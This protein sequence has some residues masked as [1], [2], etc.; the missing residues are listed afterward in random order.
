MRVAAGHGD[1]QC[2]ALCRDD[3]AGDPRLGRLVSLAGAH[4]LVEQ[5]G[6]GRAGDAGCGAGLLQARG[7][8]EGFWR[9]SWAA[10]QTAGALVGRD[11]RGGSAMRFVRAIASRAERVLVFQRT[12]QW[13][14]PHP[15]CHRPVPEDVRYLVGRVALCA[16]WYRLRTLWNFSARPAAAWVPQ[17]R[18]A[19]ADEFA[20]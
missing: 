18:S 1:R 5:P 19:I 7:G 14:I 8:G 15:D 4:R 17:L 12:G 2:D 6:A 9:R 16:G 11:R 10:M 13:A 3:L 20:G